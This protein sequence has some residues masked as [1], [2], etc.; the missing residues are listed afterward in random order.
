MILEI[1]WAKF[2]WNTKW[3]ANSRTLFKK[4]FVIAM[5]INLSDNFALSLHIRWKLSLC[6]RMDDFNKVRRGTLKRK[7]VTKNFNYMLDIWPLQISHILNTG[8]FPSEI[9]STHGSILFKLFS[10]LPFKCKPVFKNKCYCD[11]ISNHKFWVDFKIN[12]RIPNTKYHS[13]NDVRVSKD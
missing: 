11:F 4:R 8:C 13:G 7:W 9:F 2:N 12:F 6:R 1:L 5:N 10:R 3:P